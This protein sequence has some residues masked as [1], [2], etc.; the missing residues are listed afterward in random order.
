MKDIYVFLFFQE[1]RFFF[2]LCTKSNMSKEDSR[3]IRMCVTRG[4]LLPDQTFLSLK[5]RRSTFLRHI[6]S[7]HRRVFRFSNGKMFGQVVSLR[8]FHPFGSFQF[9]PPHEYSV[10]SR[11]T[12]LA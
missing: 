4:E 11:Y 2:N 12:G 8:A 7:V 1:V 6:K 5:A 9:L 3:R 10:T